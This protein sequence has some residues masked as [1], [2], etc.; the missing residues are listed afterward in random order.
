MDHFDTIVV[1]AGVAGLTAA[2]LLA[3][4]G[5][6][7]RARSPR[8]RGRPGVDRPRLRA[9]HRPRCVLDPRHHRLPRRRGGRGVRHADGRVH[10][11]RVS[12]R[13]PADR[14]LRSRWR[15]VDGCRSPAFSTTSMRSTPR[16]SRRSPHPPRTPRTATSPR[17][18]LAAQ[19]WDDERTQRVREYLQH[20][21]EEQYGAWIEDLAAHGLDDDVVDGDEVVFPDGYDRLPEALAEGLDIRLMHVV[22]RVRWSA[23]GVVVTTDHGVFSA[24]SASSRCRSACCGRPTSS[25]SRRCPNR[26]PEPWAG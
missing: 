5:A 8:P 13:Q 4:P 17:S 19:G 22:S 14:L 20:R 6:G 12:A 16:C 7:R 26:S 1:G 23:D 11:R 2:R 21:S 18:A 9:R 15:A 24:D 3:R 10:G 25:S